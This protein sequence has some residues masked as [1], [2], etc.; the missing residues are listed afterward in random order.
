MG[1][2]LRFCDMDLE[3]NGAG[4]CVGNGINESMGHPQAA[5]VRLSNFG[6]YKARVARSNKAVSNSKV[7]HSL[8]ECILPQS[9]S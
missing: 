8:P 6:Y 7:L 2:A 9:F 5:I 3:L 1:R 4:T